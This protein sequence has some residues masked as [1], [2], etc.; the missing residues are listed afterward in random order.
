MALVT[1]KTALDHLRIPYNEPLGVLT[2]DGLAEV[3]LKLS[4]AEDWA[5]EVC[6]ENYDATWDD[7]TIPGRIRSAILVYL[8]GTYDGDPDGKYLNLANRLIERWRDHVMA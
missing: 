2:A 6:G 8:T 7:Q 1:V 4:D 5:V 3:T